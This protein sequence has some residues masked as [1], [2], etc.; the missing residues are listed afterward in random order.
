MPELVTKFQLRLF[1]DE[2]DIA[3]ATVELEEF[4][5]DKPDTFELARRLLVSFLNMLAEVNAA[6][7][8]NNGKRSTA[9]NETTKLN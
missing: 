3:T 4:L 5:A 8:A 1:D 2:G 7:K 9:G 6:A